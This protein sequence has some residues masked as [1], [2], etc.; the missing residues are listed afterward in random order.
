MIEFPQNRANHTEHILKQIVSFGSCVGKHIGVFLVF[1]GILS[2]QLTERQ[3]YMEIPFLQQQQ[4]QVFR[5]LL[6]NVT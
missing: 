2:F 6:N 5:T 1:T 4:Q 3:S